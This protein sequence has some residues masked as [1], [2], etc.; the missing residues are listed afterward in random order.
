MAKNL[1]LG[2][3]S[4]YARD[5]VVEDRM[6]RF[7]EEGEGW[8]PWGQAC[9]LVEDCRCFTLATRLF[10]HELQGGLN[11]ICWSRTFS[12]MSGTVALETKLQ[13]DPTP[14]SVFVGFTVSGR[15]INTE[16][17]LHHTLG[18]VTSWHTSLL[19]RT[20][21]LAVCAISY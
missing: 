5:T 18:T 21:L 12:S 8:L 16:T 17:Q 14:L 9:R 3:H 1:P 13:A 11:N 19:R 2:L 4:L 10:C 6:L 15:R 20:T 7:I